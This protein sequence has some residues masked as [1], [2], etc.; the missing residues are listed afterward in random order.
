MTTEERLKKL[1][2]KIE[3]MQTVIRT[4]A[5]CILDDQGQDRV[6]VGMTE[7]GP[8]LFMLDENDRVLAV[9]AVNENGPRLGMRDENEK[10]RAGVAVAKEGPTLVVLDANGKPIWEA[11]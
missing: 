9:M 6:K 2:R 3:E 8:R 5:L 10:I 11:P 4:R 1:E 7:D